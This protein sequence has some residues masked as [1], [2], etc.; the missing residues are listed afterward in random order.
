MCN[1]L[2]ITFTQIDPQLKLIGL[3][4]RKLKMTDI[5]SSIYI[6]D[7]KKYALSSDFNIDPRTAKINSLFLIKCLK[8]LYEIIPFCK[9]K[10]KGHYELSG[11]DLMNRIKN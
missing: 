7:E 9:I 4:F 1:S 5:S 6:D 8:E 10:I 11:Q 3:S 2:T